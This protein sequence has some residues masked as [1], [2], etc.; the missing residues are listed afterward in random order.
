[1][2]EKVAS[3]IDLE[4]KSIIEDS[5]QRARNILESHKKVMKALVEELLKKEELSR[6]EFL[7]ILKEH[8]IKSSHQK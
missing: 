5:M 6:E 3:Q 7:K 1:M 4:I 8:D 2:S